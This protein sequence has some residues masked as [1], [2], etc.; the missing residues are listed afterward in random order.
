[1]IPSMESKKWLR[2]HMTRVRRSIKPKDRNTW[3]RSAVQHLLKSP[4]YKKSKSIAVFL[5]FASEVQTKDLIMRAWR[6]RKTVVIPITWE[7]LRKPFFAVYKKGD[8][9]EKSKYGP[10]ELKNPTK[11]FQ[12]HQLDLVVVPGLAFD[13]EG[14]RLGYGGGTY[15]ALLTK[16]RRAR[17]V[18]LFFSNQELNRLPREGHDKPLVA[19]STEKG[20]RLMETGLAKKRN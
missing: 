2:A 8:A 14:H 10:M 19:V 13:K 18:G 12:F 7:G 17:P 20:F 9:L 5:S 6:D 16:T 3:S 11:P 15:D 1:M 4:L